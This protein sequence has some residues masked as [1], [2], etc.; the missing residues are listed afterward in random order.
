MVHEKIR[1]NEKVDTQSGMRRQE[2]NKNGKRNKRKT[3]AAS[4][5]VKT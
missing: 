4:P 1:E 5:F 3:R 2:F